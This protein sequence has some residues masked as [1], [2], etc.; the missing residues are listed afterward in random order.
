MQRLSASPATASAMIRLWYDFD[1]R[2]AL[3]A[4]R[5]PTLVI[6]RAGN[7]TLPAHHSRY[8]AEHIAGAQYIEFPAPT[9]STSPATPTRCWM[10]SRNS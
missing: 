3:P 7:A 8:L 9:C 5:V 4:I 1:V 2:S 6:A 10:P